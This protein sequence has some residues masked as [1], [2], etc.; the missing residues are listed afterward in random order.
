M[1]HLIDNHVATQRMK[2]KAQLHGSGSTRTTK[3]MVYIVISRVHISRTYNISNVQWNHR[4]KDTLGSGLLSF[5]RRLSS[6]GRFNTLC[7][8]SPQ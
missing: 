1:I 2:S 7:Y 8:L 3:I 4:I 5:I 6:G